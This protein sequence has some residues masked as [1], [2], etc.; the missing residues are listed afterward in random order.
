MVPAGDLREVNREVKQVVLAGASRWQGRT[1]KRGLR[2][3][4]HGDSVDMM[5]QVE[6]RRIGFGLSL[7]LCV[8]CAGSLPVG[9]RNG[10]VASRSAY[11]GLVVTSL[12]DSED[13][14]ERIHVVEKGDTLW[15]IAQKYGIT[16][17]GL[18]GLNEVTNVRNLAVGARLVVGRQG[19]LAPVVAAEA[20]AKAPSKK[21]ASKE[22]ALRWPVNGIITVR[23]GQRRGK[24][25][26]GID[27]KAPS[28]TKVK[29][30][31]GGKVMFS[32]KHG[33][34]GHL[35]VIE[36][37][38]GLVTVYAHN[39]ENL[40]KKGDQVKAGQLIAKVGSSGKST[41]PHLHFEVRRGAN[42]QNPLRFLPPN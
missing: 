36:H 10:K 14:V 11:T 5:T 3:S 42:P 29:A 18:K 34:Y 21:K 2:P 19:G 39:R 28:G 31:R 12:S 32:A 1:T 4:N 8:G 35:V 24:P 20:T 30:A 40:V 6:G 41:S 26:D 23:Y 25:H 9:T 16:V 13:N 33:G 37:S 27:I 17:E 38:N 7:V 22:Y 15:G